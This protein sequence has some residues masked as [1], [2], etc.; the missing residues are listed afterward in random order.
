MKASTIPVWT[1]WFEAKDLR[2]D[3]AGAEAATR[4]VVAEADYYW[5]RGQQPKPVFVIEEEKPS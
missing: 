4:Q 3:V 5:E 1:G 2:F